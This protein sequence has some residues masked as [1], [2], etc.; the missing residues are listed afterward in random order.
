MNTATYNGT[1]DRFEDKFAVIKLHEGAEILWP[2]KS[3]D[4]EAT[5]GTKLTVTLAFQ[6]KEQ[7]EKT[8]LAKAM[9]NDIL[10]ATPENP[11]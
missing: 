2:A 3:L 7:T 8:M 6:L 5:T 10:N 1:I 11:K 9:L 4:P